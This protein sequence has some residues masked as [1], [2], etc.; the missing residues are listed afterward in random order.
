MGVGIVVDMGMGSAEECMGIHRYELGMN[1]DMG[2]CVA[3]YTSNP[4][5]PFIRSA[6]RKTF[7]QRISSHFSP[8]KAAAGM[9]R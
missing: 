9:K 6:K 7:L 2:M 5:P 3:T 8:Q 1:M 4:P